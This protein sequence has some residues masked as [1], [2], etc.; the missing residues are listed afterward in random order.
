MRSWQEVS[1]ICYSFHFSHCKYT[2]FLMTSKKH[3]CPMEAGMQLSQ[4]RRH[5]TL[6]SSDCIQISSTHSD[7]ADKNFN[8]EYSSI[9]TL[10]VIEEKRKGWL[11]FPDSLLREK[12]SL[13]FVYMSLSLAASIHCVCPT[14]GRRIFA[15]ASEICGKGRE[16]FCLVF[17]FWSHKER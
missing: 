10:S 2:L 11:N 12:R 16:N 8:A 6:F 17:L 9:E 13:A 14:R 1:E 15:L 4:K 7:G 3:R 5:F